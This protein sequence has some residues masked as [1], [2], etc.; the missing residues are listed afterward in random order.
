MHFNLHRKFDKY[1]IINESENFFHHYCKFTIYSFTFH[2]LCCH[3]E[4]KRISENVSFQYRCTYMV[5]SS[6]KLTN[7]FLVTLPLQTLVVCILVA[8][9]M[10]QQENSCFP[11][12]RVARHSP[13]FL[14]CNYI[15]KC[16]YEQVPLS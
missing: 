2:V 4:T 12:H 15:L 3:K 13:I 8:P 10:L 16:S 14:C 9:W 1:N 11:S 5:V 7:S 6:L